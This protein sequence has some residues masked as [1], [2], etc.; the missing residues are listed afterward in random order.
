L[1][2]RTWRHQILVLAIAVIGTTVYLEYLTPHLK[3][4][5][6]VVSTLGISLSFFIGFLN[7]HAHDR[8]M[9]ARAGFGG[10]QRG[11]RNFARMVLAYIAAQEEG[12][13]D[14]EARALQKRL[15]HRQIAVIQ[16]TKARLRSDRAEGYLEYLDDDDV[17]G[18]KGKSHVPLAILLLQARTLHDAVRSNHLDSYRMMGINAALND[19]TAAIATCDRIHGTP[20][21]PFYLTIV[22][23]AV[24][25]FLVVFPMAIADAAGYWAILYTFLIGMIFTWLVDSAYGLMKP[26]EPIHSGVAIDDL[27]RTTEIDLLQQLGEQEIP[28]PVAPVDGVYLT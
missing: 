16:A 18:I 13:E 24:W 7:S 14:R 20:F 2:L 1:L 9:Q 8:W 3:T 4:P 23:S 21:F 26:F 19:T 10:V 25:A 15:I 6:T 28:Q 11:C 5:A 27:T 22:R 17:A 12:D